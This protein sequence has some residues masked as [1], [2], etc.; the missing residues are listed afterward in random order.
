M[1]VIEVFIKGWTDFIELFCVCSNEFE[2]G[3]NSQL[4]PV[5]GCNRAVHGQQG[6]EVHI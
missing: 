6:P 4:G 1:Y 3:L 5:A 2:N